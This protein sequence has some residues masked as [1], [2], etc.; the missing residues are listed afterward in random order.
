MIAAIIVATL[1]TSGIALIVVAVVVVVRGMRSGGDAAGAH[2]ELR[3]IRVLQHWEREPNIEQLAPGTTSTSTIRIRVGLSVEQV[4]ELSATLGLP[5]QRSVTPALSAK[6]GRTERIEQSREVERSVQSSNNRTGY[7]RR[8]ALWHLVDTITIDALAPAG[9]RLTWIP[10]GSTTLTTS[11]A[12]ATT[13]VD[14]PQRAG[15]GEQR[16]AQRWY[17]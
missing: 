7:D 10:R 4:S 1:L 5:E 8:V 3:R 16:P 11:T 14:I 12:I 15:S 17:E 13:A 2:V 9:D 6:L